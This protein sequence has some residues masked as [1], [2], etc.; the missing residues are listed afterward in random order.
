MS[1]SPKYFLT[2]MICIL[3]AGS[4][5]ACG[6]TAESTPAAPFTSLGWD[7]TAEDIIAEEGDAFSTYDSI[8]GGLCYTWPREY[9]GHTG[10]VKYMFND[11]NRLV[12]VAWAYT[13]ESADE[14]RTLYESINASVGEV[15]GE[16]GYNANGVGNYGNVWH[17]ESGDIV[18]STMASTESSF[19]QYAYLHP[20]VSNQQ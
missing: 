17:P 1:I 15:Y 4:L 5:A 6:Q 10:T 7:S 14:I 9:E 11:E 13:A 18:L 12:S 20:L 8:Y 2:L 19:L 3:L 16:S